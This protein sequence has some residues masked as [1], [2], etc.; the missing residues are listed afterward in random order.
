MKK[1]CVAGALVLM[2][3]LYFTGHTSAQAQDLF[4]ANNSGAFHDAIL[5]Y[6]ET[7]AFLGIFAGEQP[8][9]SPA[10]L[11][12]DKGGDLYIANLGNDTIHRFSSTGTDL[13]AF[14]SSGLL[15][16][17]ALRLTTMA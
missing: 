17:L 16:L 4:V 2:T 7:G 13:G 1:K 14:A 11:A 9:R 3:V 6:S 8:L 12:F 5:R 15:G 10:G